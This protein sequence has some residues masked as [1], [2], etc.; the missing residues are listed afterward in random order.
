VAGEPL[1]PGTRNPGPQARM[2]AGGLASESRAGR[3]LANSMHATGVEAS[4][5]RSADS[6]SGASRFTLATGKPRRR[7]L[8][9]LNLWF[10]FVRPRRG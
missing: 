1:G 10:S 3:C 5:A 7:T 4:T 8:L 2:G 6:T 9:P